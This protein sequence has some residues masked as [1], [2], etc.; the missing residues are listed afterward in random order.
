MTAEVIYC[1][2]DQD[3][4]EAARQMQYHQIRRIPVIDRDKKLIGI[5]SLGDISVDVRNRRL[6]GEVLETVSEPAQ[7]ARGASS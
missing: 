4:G 7:P 2:E 5:V 6:S 1:F 3:V